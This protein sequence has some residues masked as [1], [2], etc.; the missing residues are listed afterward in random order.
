[1][2]LSAR[3]ADV[4]FF[5]C[6]FCRTELSVPVALQGIDGPC[7]G[8]GQNISAPLCP[9]PVLPQ[10]VYLPP[11]DRTHESPQESTE[12]VALPAETGP[13]SLPGRHRQVGL[14]PQS[15]ARTVLMPDE[16]EDDAA[17]ALPPRWGPAAMALP[18]RPLPPPAM[19]VP[20]EKPAGRQMP[21]TSMAPGRVQQAGLAG[22][23]CRS[24]SRFFRVLLL[25]MLGGLAAG[26]VLHMK[27][28]GRGMDWPWKEE[29]A[30]GPAE[31]SGAVS[32]S[33][34]F[35]REATGPAEAEIQAAAEPQPHVNPEPA[36]GVHSGVIPIETE[37]G[38]Q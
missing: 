35:T 1:M 31:V 19:T 27:N 6:G 3:P 4:L 30:R 25:V 34:W 38:N 20:G 12:A 23:A 16:G 13:V 10:R 21:L 22:P 37:P 2:Q 15:S 33:L 29:P 24:R 7:P 5:H 17:P 9:V 36:E 26:V 32:G 18:V 11:L 14:I 28:R 8:C